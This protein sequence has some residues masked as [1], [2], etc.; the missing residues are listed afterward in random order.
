VSRLPFSSAD[1]ISHISGSGGGDRFR[2]AEEEERNHCGDGGGIVVPGSSPSPAV[3]AG[4]P[5]NFPQ[6]KTLSM[7]EDSF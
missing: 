6:A 5:A 1:S 4:M 2:W 7:T 3:M